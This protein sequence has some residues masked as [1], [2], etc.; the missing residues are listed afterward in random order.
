MDP[1]ERRLA[2]SLDGLS[3]PGVL[4]DV[5][6]GNLPRRTHSRGRSRNPEPD[7]P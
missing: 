7:D 2:E 4:D 3:A 1:L 6:D 5:K